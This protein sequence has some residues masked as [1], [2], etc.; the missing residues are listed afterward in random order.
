MLEE[1]QVYSLNINDPTPRQKKSL[2]RTSSSMMNTL[3]KILLWRVVRAGV[4][5]LQ[6][7]R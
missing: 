4:T 3:S 7:Q 1:K 5:H 6:P 2:A